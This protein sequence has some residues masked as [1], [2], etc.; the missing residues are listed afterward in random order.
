MDSVLTTVRSR[1]DSFRSSA[2][3]YSARAVKLAKDHSR[4]T[5]GAAAATAVATAGI[6][7][8]L[9]GGG[10]AAAGQPS[11]VNA[12]N[13]A[14]VHTSQVQ[15]PSQAKTVKATAATHVTHTSTAVRGAH[16][17]FTQVKL[18][19]KH[20]AA[21]HRHAPARHFAVIRH[22]RA[23]ANPA[24]PYLIYDSTTPSALPSQHVAAAYA[25]GSYAASSAQMAGHKQVVW[26]DTTGHDTS[27]S[28]LD[29]EP[30]DATPG[31]AAN[32]AYHRLS[33]HPGS[34]AVI[35][36]MRSEWPAVQS[37]VGQLPQ[38]I[39][40]RVR[41][42]IADPTGVPHVVPG[43]AATQWYWGSSYDITTATPRF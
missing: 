15:T 42:W 13:H 30:G 8:G 34:L 39:Q 7:A 22:H 43:A 33:Q 29:V 12:V 17:A 9:S 38:H 35:Y 23:P 40:D 10:S 11:D 14:G 5:M 25:T 41:W 37:A 26:I 32:W 21:A 4:V 36:T 2:S 28:A 19:S 16:H 27:A 1:S 18:A 31:L 6:A 20:R 24:E 3:E